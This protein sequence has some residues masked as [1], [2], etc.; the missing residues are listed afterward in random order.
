MV[1]AKRAGYI[2]RARALVVAAAIAGSFAAGDSALG[3]PSPAASS[4]TIPVRLTERVSSSDAKAGQR[5]TFAT[6]HEATVGDVQVPAGTHGH[7]IVAEAR[8]ARWDQAGKITLEVQSLD[9][10][11]GRSL[12]VNVPT[13]A[14]T[15]PKRDAPKVPSLSTGLVPLPLVLHGIVLLGSAVQLLHGRNATFESGTTFSI[16][17]SPTAASPT[18]ASPMPSSPG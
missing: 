3:Q 11:D 5:F 12:P 8:A 10:P 15:A 1:L 17:A 9:L 16:V 18:A 4:V 7:G 2:G 13:D 6:L 14:S